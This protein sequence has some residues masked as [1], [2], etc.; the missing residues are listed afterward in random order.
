MI[1]MSLR[2]L[3]VVLL[4]GGHFDRLAPASIDGKSLI[5]AILTR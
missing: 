1:R 4:E 2:R 5:E 3:L